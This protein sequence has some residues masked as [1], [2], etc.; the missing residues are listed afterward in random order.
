MG[1]PAHPHGDMIAVTLWAGP[2]SVISHQ[3]ALAV[4][5]LAWRCPP[6]STSPLRLSR[7]AV[8]EY[9]STMK[10]WETANGTGG[11]RCP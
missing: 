4:Y 8:R 2:D 5:R 7:D 9:G 11:M 3:S 10:S 1:Y 6:R